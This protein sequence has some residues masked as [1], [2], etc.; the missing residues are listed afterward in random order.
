MYTKLSATRIFNGF[1]FEP[2]GA[3]LV[4]QQ[5][6][7]CEILYD[8]SGNDVQHVEGIIC[9]GFINAHCHLELSHLRALI[10]EKTGLIDFVRHVLNLR[11]QSF[12]TIAAAKAAIAELHATGTVAVG[13]ICNTT[14]TI[15]LKQEGLLHY[16]NFIEVSGMVT[17]T[18]SHRLNE[19]ER[20]AAH[21][22]KEGLNA[23]LV[24][25]APY[26]VSSALMMMI[27]KLSGNNC[28]TIHNQETACE[29]EFL[30]YGTGDML[31]L[32]KALNINISCFRP[33]GKTS[34]ESWQPYF[35]GNKISVHN[36]YISEFDLQTAKNTFFCL[37]VNA[38]LYIENVV[39]PI[40]LLLKYDVPVVLGTDSLASNHQLNIYA[41]IKTI[42]QY[43]PNI[44]LET[45]LKWATSNGADAL[46]LS[47]QLGSFEMGKRPGVVQINKG[48]AKTVVL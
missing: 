1:A 4:L 30:K 16:T 17:A 29:N 37:C 25:H 42:Q 47:N 31:N 35:N 13:D 26:S 45:L 2:E 36:S 28:I 41:E 33:T 44:P 15:L 24:P 46:G 18:A 14:N 3:V 40:D 19:M 43:F 20:V 8:Y 22:R 9:P 21:F 27:A 32:Y 34:F 5:G 10:P 12:D 23:T 39:P 7:I 48:F 6:K 38:N 11:N